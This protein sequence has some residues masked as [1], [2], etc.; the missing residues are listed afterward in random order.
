MVDTHRLFRNHCLHFNSAYSGSGQVRPCSSPSKPDC[1]FSVNLHAK[2]ATGLQSKHL[3]F[4]G[5]VSGLVGPDKPSHPLHLVRSNTG[6]NCRR[7]SCWEDMGLRHVIWVHEP[8]QVVVTQSYNCMGRDEG[9]GEMMWRCDQSTCK[10]EDFMTAVSF[11][12]ISHCFR[13]VWL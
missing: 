5:C 6:H 13:P 10:G 7:G 12:Q 1:H 8:W 9:C 4:T 11:V 2:Q 3:A